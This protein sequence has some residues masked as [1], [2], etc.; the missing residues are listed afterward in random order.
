MTNLQYFLGILSF[1]LSSGSNNLFFLNWRMTCPN[2][3]L[4]PIELDQH[5]SLSN[6]LSPTL[7]PGIN[8]STSLLNVSATAECWYFQHQH[9]RGKFHKGYR[10]VIGSAG[11]TEPMDKSAYPVM[12][13]SEKDPELTLLRPTGSR[14]HS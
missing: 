4:Q 14:T 5:S 7:C 13:V 1:F 11:D 2:S 6:A 10:G 3:K 12:L 8:Y 9:R